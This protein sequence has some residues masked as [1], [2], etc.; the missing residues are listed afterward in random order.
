MF[1]GGAGYRLPTEAEWEYAC[2]AGHSTRY[3]FGDRA[4]D[5]GEYAWIAGNSENKTHV[6]GQ[7]RANA[8]GL[9]D[10]NGNVW[11][12][13]LDNYDAEYYRRLGP[14]TLDPRGP[15][16]ATG[17][18][19]Q[20]SVKREGLD[21]WSL[22]SGDRL[23]IGRVVRG[24]GCDNPARSYRSAHRFRHVPGHR[25]PRLGFRLVRISVAP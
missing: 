12:W 25:G 19:S 24:G 1:S 10:M 21:N 16:A 7:K 13:C 22:D 2:R 6:V 8:F 18:L 11:E 5:L 20:A 4:A 15:S 14:L 9:H 3:S 17:R 23:A